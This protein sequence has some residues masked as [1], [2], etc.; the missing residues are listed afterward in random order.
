MFSIEIIHEKWFLSTTPRT[1]IRLCET[2]IAIP[3]FHK[4]QGI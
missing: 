4:A 1:I 3:F 2:D